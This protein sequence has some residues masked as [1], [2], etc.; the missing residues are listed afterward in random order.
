[1]SKNEACT[2]ALSLAMQPLSRERLFTKRAIDYETR[3][4]FDGHEYH[5]K[6][7]NL[8]TPRCRKCGTTLL[9]SDANEKITRELLR[10][11]KLL[12]PRQIQKYRKSLGLTQA[13]LAA[14][15]DVSDN[16]AAYWEDGL[17][18]PTRAQDNMLRLF[19]GSPEARDLM[20]KRMLSKVGLVLRDK[21]LA[22]T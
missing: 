2:E 5:I 13:E 15:L 11:A 10:Q 3:L 8:K 14:S 1:M 4:E 7:P 18:I 9:D 20:T 21:S 6:L 17:L 19:F 12:T 16:I 22:A